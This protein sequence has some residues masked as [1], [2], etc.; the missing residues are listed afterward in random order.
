MKTWLKGG[1]IGL[2]VAV[3][4]EIS[5]FYIMHISPL[6]LFG[7]LVIFPIIGIIVGVIIG[8]SKENVIGKPQLLKK[9]KTVAE[10]SLLK[11]FIVILVI[12]IILTVLLYLY[13]A[14]LPRPSQ[15]RG[16][17]LLILPLMTF[18]LPLAVP[19]SVV[20]TACTI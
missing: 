8:K 2:V 1:L 10:P 7:I 19:I 16:F 18:L 3:L 11:Y 9:E 17:D 13:N 12:F 14:V 20:D 5:T 6:T 15:Y 4:I